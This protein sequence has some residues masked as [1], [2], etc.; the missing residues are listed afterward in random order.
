MTWAAFHRRSDVLRAV[1]DEADMRQ[2]G[3]VPM[4]IDGVTETFRDEADLVAT[5]HLR[6]HTRLVGTIERALADQ[7]MDLTAAVATA[8]ADTAHQM[9]G[10]LAILDRAPD[11][12][13]MQTARAK[14]HAMLAVMAG[15]ASQSGEADEQTLAVGRDIEARGRAAYDATPTRPVQQAGPDPTPTHPAQQAAPASEE[16]R[17]KAAHEDAQPS[18]VERL[19]A[20]VAAA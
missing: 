9:P 8:W 20:A 4:H 16:G 3:L 17:H 12:A 13:A 7:P 11:T 2:D 18:F 1:I 10:I 5:L 6:W 15:L 19:K 14:E